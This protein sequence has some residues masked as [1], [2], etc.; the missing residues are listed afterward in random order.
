MRREMEDRV[1]PAKEEPPITIAEALGR[2]LADCQ[3]RNL[4][5]ATFTKYRHLKRQLLKFAQ[6]N[7]YKFLRELDARNMR[8]FRNSWTTLGPL[9]SA[10]QLER[11][12][13]F[14]RYCVDSDLTEKNPAKT[15]RPPVLKLR[16]REPLTES[17][18][19]RLLAWANCPA[20]APPD[21]H[22]RLTPPHPKTPVFLKLLLFSA[23]RITDAATL[24]RDRIQDGKLFLYAAK[25]GR[26]VRAPLPPD[27]VN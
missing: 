16:P 5:L 27:L 10:K 21:D 20:W 22:E 11:L 8:D 1:R 9:T 18:Q 19:E 26:P 14:F 7:G 13:S 15:I 2:F 3:A 17:E 23:L 4:N 25:N 12:R 24:T 6:A